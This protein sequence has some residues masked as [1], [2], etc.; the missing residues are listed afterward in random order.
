M[1]IVDT[2]NASYYAV[3]FT[4]LKKNDAKEYL[5]MAEKMEELVKKLGAGL[6]LLPLTQ[7]LRQRLNK[8]L[9]NFLDFPQIYF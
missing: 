4:S 2:P 3:I 1:K 6:G 9:I 8:F 5:E 7:S